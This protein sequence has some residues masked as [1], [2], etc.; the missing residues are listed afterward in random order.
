MTMYSEAFEYSKLTSIGSAAGIFEL[1][2]LIYYKKDKVL[3]LADQNGRY[4][5]N[6]NIAFLTSQWNCLDGEISLPKPTIFD[7]DGKLIEKGDKV[8]YVH[9]NE[10]QDNVI[11]LGIYQNFLHHLDEKDSE[12]KAYQ[13]NLK[14]SISELKDLLEKKIL[15]R[16]SKRIYEVIEDSEGNLSL[17]L[18]GVNT[19][20]GNLNIKIKGTEG[21]GQVNL[22][23]NGKINILQKDKSDSNVIAKFSM[24]NENGKETV[25]ITDKYKNRFEL[26]NKGTIIEAET[27]NITGKDSTKEITLKTLLT[28]LIDAI[29]NMTQPTNTGST[30]APPVNMAEFLKIKKNAEMLL[31][32][33]K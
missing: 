21:N 7:E 30:I 31:K 4:Y 15:R 3:L 29:V 16:N 10:N 19:G 14:F 5:D 33:N 20:K 8:I 26:N 11:I 12:G 22:E 6:I 25:I 24:D 2:E 23:L 18:E 13:K 32:E 28:D 27:I 17:Y 9:V 1:G